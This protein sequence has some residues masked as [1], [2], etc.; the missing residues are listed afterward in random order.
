MTCSEVTSVSLASYIIGLATYNMHSKVDMPPTISFNLESSMNPNS[1]GFEVTDLMDFY[2][3][4]IFY[5]LHIFIFQL[6]DS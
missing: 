2:L 6:T 4:S 5:V 3:I 1:Q